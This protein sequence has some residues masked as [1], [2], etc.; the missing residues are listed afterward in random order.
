M[1]F[2]LEPSL[3]FTLGLT[4]PDI[5]L[6]MGLMHLNLTSGKLCGSHLNKSRVQFISML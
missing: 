5:T 1:L 4:D 6:Q 3:I 2:I